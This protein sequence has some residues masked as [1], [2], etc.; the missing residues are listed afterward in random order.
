MAKS[1]KEGTGANLRRSGSDGYRFK[2]W[3]Q[4]GLFAV[5]SPLKCTLPLVICI[6]NINSCVDVLVD[7]TFAL[8]ERDVT[9]AQ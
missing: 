1:C 8:R 6:H 2:T 5:E 3:C 9:S 4:Q 7:C